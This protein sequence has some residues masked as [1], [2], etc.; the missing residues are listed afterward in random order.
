MDG[1][2]QQGNSVQSRKN[3]DQIVQ[4]AEPDR[5]TPAADGKVANDST[6]S[7]HERMG[8]GCDGH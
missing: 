8:A 5:E 3:F 4:Y 6:N 2:C 7:E 1:F